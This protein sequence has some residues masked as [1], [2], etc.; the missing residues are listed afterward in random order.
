MMFPSPRFKPFLYLNSLTRTPLLQLQTPKSNQ[1]FPP[2]LTP[3]HTST[4]SQH[5]PFKVSYLV[6]TCGFSVETALKL[7]QH[8]SKTTF[9]QH[10]LSQPRKQSKGRKLCQNTNQNHSFPHL[11]TPVTIPSIQFV[12]RW[13]DSRI[14][15]EVSS[16]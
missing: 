8:P 2:S 4:T 16:T 3:K 7:P 12:N 15:L 9:K 11:K 10:K 6:S 13:I 14:L 1:T 5:H